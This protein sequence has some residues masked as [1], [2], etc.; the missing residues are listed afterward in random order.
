MIIK[1]SKIK[2]IIIEDDSQAQEYLF[3]ILNE[4]FNNIEIKGYAD[5]IEKSVMLINKEKP[6]LVFMDIELKDGL[7]FEI[8]NYLNDINF[9]VIFITA[10]DH[11]IQRAIDHF[12]FSFIVKPIDHQKLIP[13]VKRYTN[14]KERLFTQKK[15]DLFQTFINRENPQFLLHTGNEYISVRVNDIIKFTAEGNYT[16]FYL[17]NGETYLASK[18]LKYYYELLKDQGF[19]KAHRSVVINI[20]YIASIYKKETILLKNK[21][22]I[23]I[24]ARNKPNLSNLIAILS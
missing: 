6:E 19:F 14:L 8:F 3:S 17:L 16:K 4:N 20:D 1:G 23:N 22:K 24:S 21:E 12:A 15:Y 5:S 7:S 2:A 9:E 13:S 18:I 10:Y 11:F